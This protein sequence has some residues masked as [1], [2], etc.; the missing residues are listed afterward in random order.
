MFGLAY[1]AAAIDN[2]EC[3]ICHSNPEASKTGPDGRV[4]S[5]YIDE[6]LYRSSVHGEADCTMCHVDIEELPH[7]P[8]LEAVDCGVCHY[9][10]EE[11]NMGVHGAAHALGDPDAAFCKDC[12][13]DHNVRRS[14]DPLS[15]VHP[16][17]QPDT[18][19]KCHNDPDLVKNHMF[20]VRDPGDAYLKSI[21]ATQIFEEGNLEAA[22]C[23]DCHG[24][25]T[26]LPQQD[27][28]SKVFRGNIAETCGECHS[29]VVDAYMGSIHGK[30]LLAGVPDAPTCVDCHGEHDISPAHIEGSPVNL[31]MVS[32][33]T[34]PKCH[35][36]AQVM[37]KY[38]IE[39][40]RQA[41][42]MDSYHGM[43]SAAGSKVVASCVS[44]HGVHDIQPES[45]PN[46]RIHPDNLVETCAQ[47]HENAG[48]NFAV[49]AVHIAPTAPDQWVLGLVRML[50]LWAIVAVLGGMVLHN[51][52]MMA[53]HAVVKFQQERK[54]PRTYRRFTKGQ[55]MGHLVLSIAF[56]GLV[57][58]GF[59]LR[60]PEAWW[61]RVMF[62]GD[63]GLEVRAQAHRICAV[64][65]TAVMGLNLLY[66]LF[67]R[68]GRKEL[69]ALVFTWK[70]IKDIFRNLGYV[71]G[72]RKHEPQYDR[73]NYSEK[74]EYWGLWWGSIIM[75]ATGFCMWFPNLFLAYFPKLA[76]DAI[77]LIH[78]YEAW[79]ATGTIAIWHF[80]YMIFDPETYP[81]NWSWITGHITEEDF[82]ERHPLEYERILKENGGKFP[83][84]KEDE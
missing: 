49:G 84:A 15:L 45:D 83:A 71:V 30:A 53:R 5:L 8:E 81:M 67:S 59:A 64:M 16:L 42:Y 78:Y 63:T 3:M 21:H 13:G 22:S 60:F 36:D 18:C 55:T 31:Q 48:P 41:S 37:T 74:M 57:I 50:Y 40:M 2:A 26:I 62:F 35:D 6:E 54:G 14:S 76:L 1:T 33:Q 44:C 24:H 20:S 52:L 34:C 28:E 19:G 80:Y 75:I 70:D 68:P 65:L 9:Q 39:A 29:D 61:S 58:S 82:K 27:P 51:S 32:R 23:N 72:L 10:M 73:Y 46:S 11:Y 79:L 17:N 66:I 69:R 38:G 4:L 77:A 56:I 12:H 7:V 43:M 25:H 47:C